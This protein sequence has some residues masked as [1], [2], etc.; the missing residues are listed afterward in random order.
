V[1]SIFSSTQILGPTAAALLPCTLRGIFVQ[2]GVPTLSGFFA[3]PS[4]SAGTK[5]TRPPIPGALHL[6]YLD[7]DEI[8]K[9]LL[10]IIDHCNGLI[11]LDHHVVN[12]ATRQW[13]RLLPYSPPESSP[14]GSEIIL[15]G[16][17]ALVF[18]PHRVAAALP[19]VLDALRP[20]TTSHGV[21]SMSSPI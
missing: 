1:C 20:R 17:H 4:P 9:S 15:D 2:I 3:C 5:T 11:L 6:D 19:G 13:M 14:P 16:Y 10:T 8:E 21:F 18:D 7:T 12:P